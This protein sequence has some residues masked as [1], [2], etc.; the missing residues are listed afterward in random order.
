M[1][2]TLKQQFDLTNKVAILTGASKGIG[3]SMAH[4]LAT[5]GAK[6][7]VSSRK[8]ES[9]N[10]VATE[11]KQQGLEA[12]A[13]A[14][15]VGDETQLKNLVEQTIE[16]YGRIDILINNAATNPV[17]GPLSDMNEAVFDKVMNVNVK[18]CML[19]SNLCFP[20]MKKQGGGSIIN[21]ASIEGLKPSPGMSLYSISKAALIMLSQSQAKE[22]G[23]LGIRSNALCPG[24]VQTKFSAAIW[25]NESILKNFI[26][27]LPLGRMAQP[28]EMTGITL[29][30]ASDASKFCTGGVYTVDGGHMVV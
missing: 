3:K 12:T 5:Y 25:Q 8:Q 26:S 11:L 29:F 17:F 1:N 19:L 20:H 22:W 28:D 18:A 21:V 30:L 2:N 24:L 4:M 10:E 27:Q 9:V 13:I 14:C 15:H 23:A 6:V 16:T 7:V